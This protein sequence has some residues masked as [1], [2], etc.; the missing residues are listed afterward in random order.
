MLL[1]DALKTHLDKLGSNVESLDFQEAKVVLCS[2]ADILNINL[3][4]DSAP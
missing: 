3:D 4:Q 2:I 1:S